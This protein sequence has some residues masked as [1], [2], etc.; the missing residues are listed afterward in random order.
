[1][2]NNVENTL[3]VTGDNA[4]LKKLKSLMQGKE[5]KFDFNKILPSPDVFRNV[6][7]GFTRIGG[8]GHKLWRSLKGKD[9]KEKNIAI[10]ARTLKEWK[11]K[12][13]AD[14]WYEWQ[15]AN[16]GTKWNAYNVSFCGGDGIL[17]YF[18]DTAWSSPEPVVMALSKKFPSL[19]FKV[20]VGGEV[21]LEYAYYAK[22]GQLMEGK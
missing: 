1:M 9:G 10:P 22:D 19:D 17:E 4:D 13:G 6:V 18:F 14:N 20:D 21:D 16:W 7:S 11:K 5:S 3:T 8:R 2:P 12:Y 15:V